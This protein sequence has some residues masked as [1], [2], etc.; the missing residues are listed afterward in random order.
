MTMANCRLADIFIP[1]GFFGAV[2]KIITI[3]DVPRSRQLR[4]DRRGTSWPRQ[5][6]PFVTAEDFKTMK[7]L[8]GHGKGDIRRD[9]VPDPK[10]FRDKKHG[11]IKVVLKTVMTS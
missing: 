10:A 5:P 4:S 7:A 9:S 8:A 11:C 1:L 2:L 6:F 3:I